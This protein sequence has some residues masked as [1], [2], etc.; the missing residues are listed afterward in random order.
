MLEFLVENIFVV[1]GG[2]GNFPIDS[3]HSNGHKLC[4]S[5]SRHISVLIRSGR[6]TVFAPNW[7]EKLAS[8]FNF[9]YRYIDEVLTINNPDFENYL[10]QMYIPL[11]LRSKTRRRTAPLL[12]TWIYSCRSGVTVSCPLP[13][14]TNET[15]S[16]SI[17]QTFR[18]CVEIF[19]LRLHM[20]FY[21]TA[22]TVCQGLLLLWM[23]H[24]KGG[25][26]FI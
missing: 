5:P 26:T 16:T 24:S 13:F 23:L 3:R 20:V 9:T 6:H 21:F 18:S 8:Q 22:H 4:P 7:K 17:S 12:P 25:A 15:I 10:G 11:S 19:H 2:G 1:F 14:T